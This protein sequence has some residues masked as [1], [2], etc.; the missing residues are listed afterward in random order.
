MMSDIYIGSATKI[1]DLGCGH[2]KQYF[3]PGVTVIGVDRT[4]DSHAD[5]VCE[6][7]FDAMPFEDS[8]FDFAIANHFIEH[9]PN[10]FV[11]YGPDLKLHTSRPVIQL[12]NDV[13]RVLKHMGVFHIEVPLVERGFIPAFQDPTHVSYWTMETFHYFSGD[14]FSHH[15]TYGHT[16]RFQAISRHVKNGWIGV[17]RLQAIKN[18]PV[19]APYKLFYE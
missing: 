16:S 9:V 13:Y 5:E 4:P 15:D 1:V 14:Y 10:I 19:D 2:N 12:F 11:Y 17:I 3:G 7:G 6:L 8:T 18:L